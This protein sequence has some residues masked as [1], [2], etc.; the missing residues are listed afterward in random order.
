MQSIKE[1]SI[2][3]YIS[4][5]DFRNDDW[6]LTKLKEDMRRFLGEEPAIEIV[7][8]KD[9]LINEATLEAKE[10]VNIDKVQIIF[11]DLDGRFK[12]LEFNVDKLN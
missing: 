12:K 10:F 4:K 5:I 7:Y 11:T 6:K 3:D 9:V 2:V 1:I 8:K